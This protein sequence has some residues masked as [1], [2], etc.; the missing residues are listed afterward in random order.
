M[1]GFMGRGVQPPTD[2]LGN[3]S[4]AGAVALSQRRFAEA[5][6]LLV[7]A[8]E[9]ANQFGPQDARLGFSLNNLA[10]LYHAQGQY[11]RA[12]EFAQ[13]AMDILQKALG[14]DHLFVAVMVEN[15]S[16]LL[17][18]MGRDVE[19]S[20]MT[21]RANSIRARQSRANRPR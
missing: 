18:M 12:E 19:A 5:E 17:R 7:A 13:R 9:D 11:A 16:A 4:R 21:A 8:L 10:G 1:S 2:I 3:Y 6:K 15:Y 14:S 20:K